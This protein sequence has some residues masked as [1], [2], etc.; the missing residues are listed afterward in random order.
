MG[1]TRIAFR[2][3][4]DVLHRIEKLRGLLDKKLVGGPPFTLSAAVRIALLRGIEVLEKELSHI[5]KP[6]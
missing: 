6:V 3:D 4:V 2:A 1:K 5:R